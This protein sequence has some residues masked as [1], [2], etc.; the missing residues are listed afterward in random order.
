M[1]DEEFS[2]LQDTKK[3]APTLWKLLDFPDPSIEYWSGNNPFLV[4]S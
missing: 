1:L 4:K 3:D 2:E